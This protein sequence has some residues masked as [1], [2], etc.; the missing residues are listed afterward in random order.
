[1]LPKP[2]KSLLANPMLDLEQALSFEFYY[3]P[4]PHKVGYRLVS[5]FKKGLRF[6]PAHM[7]KLTQAAKKRGSPASLSHHV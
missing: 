6:S 2:F 7:M 4:K 5:H 3:R 1:M